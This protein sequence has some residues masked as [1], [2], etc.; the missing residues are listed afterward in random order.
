MIYLLKWRAALVLSGLIMTLFT[1][2]CAQ[3]SV[4]HHT[5][6]SI[7]KRF[8][9]ILGYVCSAWAGWRSR[10]SDWLRAGR[11]GDRI[12]VGDEIFRNCPDRPWG[13]TSLLY[14]GYRVFRR[15]KERP[16]RGADPS[17]LL[18]PWPNKSRLIPLVSL[19]A[20]WPIQSLSACTRVHFT[21]TFMCVLCLQE[22]LRVLH[23]HWSKSI[24]LILRQGISAGTL[25]WTSLF[26]G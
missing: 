6:N 2:I 18:V 4:E 14:N 5:H 11:S 24:Q 17:P 9:Y 26:L 19:W 16:G 3:R 15:G 8:K 12:P 22:A 7:S 10:Y 21:F 25:H 20:V 1:Y 23:T 13:S